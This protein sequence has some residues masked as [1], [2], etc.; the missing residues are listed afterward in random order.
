M[1]PNRPSCPHNT[2]ATWLTTRDFPGADRPNRVPVTPARR[3]RRM[4]RLF[5]S[6]R[7]TGPTGAVRT[8][9]V[10]STLPALCRLPDCISQ[11]GRAKLKLVQK[12]YVVVLDMKLA[13]I[14]PIPTVLSFGKQSVIFD[15]TRAHNPNDDFVA[16]YGHPYEDVTAL[17]LKLLKIH[18][19]WLI[20]IS[21]QGFN[22]K[23]FFTIAIDRSRCFDFD[24]NAI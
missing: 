22:V 1:I 14:P 3:Y 18:Q 12:T 8:N 9:A 20:R 7:L 11:I 5:H 13:L 10:I 21:R 16:K 17:R 4:G 24:F 6:Y 15:L 23:G 2:P 19:K